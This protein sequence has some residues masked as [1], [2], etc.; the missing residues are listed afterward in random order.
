MKDLRH[1]CICL[2]RIM[3]LFKKKGHKTTMNGKIGVREG[4]LFV[5]VCCQRIM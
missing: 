2:P 1:K 5:V 4:L 3:A